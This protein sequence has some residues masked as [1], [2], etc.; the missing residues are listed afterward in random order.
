MNDFLSRLLLRFDAPVRLTYCRLGPVSWA[1]RRL[2]R[3]KY[4]SVPECLMCNSLLWRPLFRE[5]GVDL[6]GARVVELGP[7]NSAMNALLL[8]LEGAGKVVM[9]D[10]YPRRDRSPEQEELERR[11]AEILGLCP[12]VEERSI[13]LR[14]CLAEGRI[15]YR[16]GDFLTMDLGGFDLLFTNSVLEHLENPEDCVRRMAAMIKP[17]GWAWHLI[18][19]R[20]HYN[21]RAPWLFLRFS[22]RAWERWLSK[23]GVSYLNRWRRDDF[24]AVFRKHGFE[25]VWEDATRM[26]I[27]SNF[28][29]APRF[30]SK[31]SSELGKAIWGVLLRRSPA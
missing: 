27:P 24:L 2:A 28:P 11:E 3:G 8:V 4:S 1:L 7:G 12:W 22:D 21:F 29:L 19:L 6:R 30:Q 31:P 26:D 23:P 14:K 17:G 9:V 5:H 13:D 10:K 15:E 18:D 20:D 16:A 25:L